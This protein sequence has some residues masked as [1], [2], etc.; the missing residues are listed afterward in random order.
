MSRDADIKIVGDLGEKIVKT[1]LEALGLQVMMS[2]SQYDRI[3]DMVVEG[4]TVEVKTLTLIKKY[5]AYCIEPNQW[6]KLDN[7][8]RLFFVVI[9][10]YGNPVIVYEAV[11]KNHFTELFNGGI[12]RFYP[13]DRMRKFCVIRDNDVERTL[14][15]HTDSNFIIRGEND[16]AP[17]S[18]SSQ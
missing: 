8:N 13:K 11:E 17:F 5:Q 9:P 14:R 15:N 16:R 4:E 7:V 1:S 18:S 3:K 12:K 2:E 6:K 10:N